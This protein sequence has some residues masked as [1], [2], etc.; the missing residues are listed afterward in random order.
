MKK[1]KP[2]IGLVELGTD[3][4]ERRYLRERYFFAIANAKARV[5]VLP[6]IADLEQ[7]KWYLRKCDGLILPG[8]PDMDLEPY[9]IKNQEYNLY[10]AAARDLCEPLY[11]K[12]AMERK[13]PVLG[14]CRGC[15]L[16]NV[17]FGGTLYQDI[18]REVPGFL[19]VHRQK[20][21]Y[22][23][24]VH[25]VGVIEGSL[26]EEITGEKE[27]QVNSMHH[28]A[29]NQLAPCLTKMAVSPDGLTEAVA[30]QGEQWI[31]GVQWHP[32]WLVRSEASSAKLFS[33]FC[34]RASHRK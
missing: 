5:K 30:Y 19:P 23:K 14:I 17:Y 7:A 9:G 32:E 31:V 15:Q 11:L 27:L 21:P 6:H 2:L 29:V 12:S 10:T 18:P 20:A 3:T 13:L 24:P 1:R 8:G 34:E 22:Q 16:L 33:V 28:Q 25:T 26:L 4:W